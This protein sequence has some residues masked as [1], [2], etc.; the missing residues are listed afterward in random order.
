MSFSQ[1]EAECSRGTGSPDI[2]TQCGT[3]HGQS[4]HWSYCWAA[5]ISLDMHCDLRLFYPTCLPRSSPFTGVRPALQS[6][7]ASCSCPLASLSFTGVIPRTLSHLPCLGIYFPEHQLA[8]SVTL[9]KLRNQS[10]SSFLICKMG[11]VT[12]RTAQ[13]SRED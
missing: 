5:E 1:P 9:D 4:L 11:I 3:F 8:H 6:E 10:L 13:F 7:G 2:S 12:V